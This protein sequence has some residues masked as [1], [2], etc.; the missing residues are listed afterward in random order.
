MLRL[1]LRV[2]SIADP[3]RSLNLQF[4]LPS[5]K[6]CVPEANQEDPMMRDSVLSSGLFRPSAD[7]ELL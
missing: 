4:V 7:E 6:F 3:Q 2:D 1:R 5:D